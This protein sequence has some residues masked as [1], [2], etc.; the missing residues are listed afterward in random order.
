MVATVYW[1]TREAS[2]ALS[3]RSDGVIGRRSLVGTRLGVATSSLSALSTDGLQIRGCSDACLDNGGTSGCCLVFCIPSQPAF[4]EERLPA[5]IL[6]RNN[7]GIYSV[8]SIDPMTRAQKYYDEL[9]G[10]VPTVQPAANVSNLMENLTRM[11]GLAIIQLSP[12]VAWKA[13]VT[14]KIWGQPVINRW[15][16]PHFTT[17]KWGSAGSPFVPPSG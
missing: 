2:G 4:L 12:G 1:Q 7:V 3:G 14:V 8:G 11:D 15:C 5:F 6:L 13:L 9:L 16:L 17:I 10:P